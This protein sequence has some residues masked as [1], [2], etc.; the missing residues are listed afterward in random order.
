MTSDW[1]QL[2]DELVAALHPTAP[3]IAITFSSARPEGVDAFDDPMP[4]AVAPRRTHRQG[5]GRL[6]VLDE[7]GGPHVQHRRRRPWELQRR[8]HDPRLRHPRG[9]RGPRRRGDA[10]RHRM[11]DRGAGPG[12]P[13]GQ[14]AA[15]CPHLRPA[16]RHTRRPRRGAGPAHRQVPDVP[17]RR[18]PRAGGGEQ[19][20]VPHLALAK[21]HDVVAASVGCMLSRV[22]TGMPSTET[23]CAIP[24]GRLAELV[25]AVRRTA[26]VNA[27]VA[28]YA[29]G[30]GC[31][32]GEGARGD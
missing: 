4:P 29:A 5:G 8:Q 14:P 24:A 16:D 17:L 10:A 11:G 31:R 18:G 1:A 25:G 15:G 20:A 26:E 7:G 22:R 13:R 19:A 23:T 28:R 30:D 27:T 6:R 3:P 12:H 21:E 2:S 9:G 32:F